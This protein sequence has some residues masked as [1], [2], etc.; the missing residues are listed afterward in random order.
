MR[1][2][3][4]AWTRLAFTGRAEIA[5][6]LD[7]DPSTISRELRRS[8]SRPPRQYRAFPA[9]IMAR[10]RAWRPKPVIW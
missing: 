2:V 6:A 4:V 5:R 3:L 1:E 9:H 8:V 7:R 10:E